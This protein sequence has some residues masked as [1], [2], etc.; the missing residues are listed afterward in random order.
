MASCSHCTPTQL[1]HH[2]SSSS[3]GF[4]T[5]PYPFLHTKPLHPDYHLLV[6]SSPTPTA[7]QIEAFQRAIATSGHLPTLHG[8]QWASPQNPHSP[9]LFFLNARASKA[10]AATGHSGEKTNKRISGAKRV[11]HRQKALRTRSPEGSPEGNPTEAV[12]AQLQEGKP[13]RQSKCSKPKEHQIG[14]RLRKGKAVTCPLPSRRAPASHSSMARQRQPGLLK[15][16]RQLLTRPVSWG[17]P[18]G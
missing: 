16:A 6:S 15:S 8:H 4:P 17:Y 10:L 9:T 7:A 18:E 12:R 2:R 13:R 11:R 14:H 3:I 5:D 1:A